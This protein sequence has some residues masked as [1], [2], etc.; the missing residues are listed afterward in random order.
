MKM[1]AKSRA[2]LVSL[3][4]Y[5]LALICDVTG[6]FPISIHEKPDRKPCHKTFYILQ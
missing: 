5:V 4:L 6:N 2:A 1:A 3:L